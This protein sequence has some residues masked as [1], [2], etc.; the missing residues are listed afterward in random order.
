MTDI[1]VSDDEAR[2]LGQHQVVK[3]RVEGDVNAEITERAAHATHTETVAVDEIASDLRSRAIKET[4]G[5]ERE[6]VRARG[7]ARSSQ[8]IDYA[9]YVLYSLLAVR[10]VLALIAAN[11]RSGFVKFIG[12]ITGL[13]VAPFRGIVPSLGTEGGNILALP[14]VVALVIYALVHVGING[15]LRLMAQRKT[16]I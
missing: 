12:A 15:G 14:I 13:F 2:R 7:A 9:F 1:K 4:V 5:T 11:P 16:E 6:L 10:L 8:F 3:A